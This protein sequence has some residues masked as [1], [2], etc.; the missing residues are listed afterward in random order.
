M[1]GR[2]PPGIEIWLPE[3]TNNGKT[4][5]VSTKKAGFRSVSH[6]SVVVL[7][8]VEFGS[9]E[10]IKIGQKLLVCTNKA[11]FLGVSHA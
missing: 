3:L 5:L 2:W 9:P 7:P 10:L 1:R 11:A 4:M 8:G 6:A